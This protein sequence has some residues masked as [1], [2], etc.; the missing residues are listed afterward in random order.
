MNKE[1]MKT[2]K[3][4]LSNVNRLLSSQIFHGIDERINYTSVGEKIKAPIETRLKNSKFAQ[5]MSE[6]LDNELNVLALVMGFAPKGMA[7]IEM[8]LTAENSR[9][10]IYALRQELLH[11]GE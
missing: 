8:Y 1:I 9:I 5:L 6:L 7:A 3:N 10:Q 4:E 2:E 11:R